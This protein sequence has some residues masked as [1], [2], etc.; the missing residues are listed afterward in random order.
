MV[1][2]EGGFG[3]NISIGSFYASFHNVSIDVK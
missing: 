1:T 2:K 3:Q